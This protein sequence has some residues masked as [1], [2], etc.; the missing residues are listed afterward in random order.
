MSTG[1][2]RRAP[3]SILVILGVVAAICVG[4]TFA[5]WR[6][7]RLHR[8]ADATP[9]GEPTLPTSG[10]Q[11]QRWTQ[12]AVARGAQWQE[13]GAEGLDGASAQQEEQA[14]SAEEPH[15]PDAGELDPRAEPVH[16]PQTKQT[17]LYLSSIRNTGTTK[18]AWAKPAAK[19]LSDLSMS[20]GPGLRD[21]VKGGAP[22]CYRTGCL[23]QFRYANLE[24]FRQANEAFL[25]D[26]RNGLNSWDGPRERTPPVA[27]G[28]EIV[29]AW[30]L[31]PDPAVG[32]SDETVSDESSGDAGE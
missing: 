9:A 13:Q 24:A 26:A 22:E 17:D 8:S 29:S 28:G 7:T 6:T 15:A 25:T 2:R 14:S 5:V 23:I 20:L 16:P 21:L 10:A 27:E 31:M 4:L 30:V 19:A 1:L 12:G 18:A 11:R 32:A 3:L